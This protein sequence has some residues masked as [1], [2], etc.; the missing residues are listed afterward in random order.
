MALIVFAIIKTDFPIITSLVLSIFAG[1]FSYFIVLLI[2]RN[3]LLYE[4]VR[5]M[6]WS[7]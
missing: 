7:K 3:E 6:R 4:F 1:A 2:L 5:R